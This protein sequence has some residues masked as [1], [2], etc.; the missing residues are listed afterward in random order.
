MNQNTNQEVE[1]KVRLLNMDFEIAGIQS[2]NYVKLGQVIYTENPDPYNLLGIGTCLGIYMFDLKNARYM[3]AHTMLPTMEHMRPHVSDEMPA[4]FTDQ[5]IHFMLRRLLREGSSKRD[6]KVRIAGG[7]QIYNDSLNIG[8]RNI[9]IARQILN[10]ENIEI[11]GEDVG[12]HIGR[13]ILEF[14]KDGTMYIKKNGV[15][16]TI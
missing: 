7:A 9:E 3:M 8:T 12:G 14:Y 1:Q 2:K 16:F 13:S 11:L 10:D 4:R 15:K 6:I 5:G